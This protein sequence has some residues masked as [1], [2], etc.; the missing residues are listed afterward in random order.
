MLLEETRSIT[1]GIERTHISGNGGES[2]VVRRSRTHRQQGAL[3]AKSK[4]LVDFTNKTIAPEHSDYLLQALERNPDPQFQQTY[5]NGRPL[6]EVIDSAPIL[7]VGLKF[8]PGADKPQVNR[9]EEMDMVGKEPD[10]K[11]AAW[12]VATAGSLLSQLTVYPDLQIVHTDQT[13]RIV[14]RAKFLA[15]Q[16]D[17]RFSDQRKAL[18]LRKRQPDTVTI[19]S[20]HVTIVKDL[21]NGDWD[22]RGLLVEVDWSSL[23]DLMTNYRNL[24]AGGGPAMPP[25]ET[26]TLLET[27]IEDARRLCIRSPI[28]FRMSTRVSIINSENTRYGINLGSN[29]RTLITSQGIREIIS[30]SASYYNSLDPTGTDDSVQ[31]FVRPRFLQ[32][33]VLLLSLLN[34]EDLAQIKDFLEATYKIK[35]NRR[36]VE[37]LIL[38]VVPLQSINSRVFLDA[39]VPAI[40]NFPLDRGST[41]NDQAHSEI[42]DIF[43]KRILADEY[44]LPGTVDDHGRKQLSWIVKW[45]DQGFKSTAVFDTLQYA[46]RFRTINEIP[47]VDTN[48]VGADSSELTIEMSDDSKY[49][50]DPKD[51]E[52]IIYMTPGVYVM[53]CTTGR[54]TLQDLVIEEKLLNGELYT[55]IDMTNAIVGDVNSW[56]S[57]SKRDKKLLKWP[58][59]AGEHFSL[60]DVQGTGRLVE[61]YAFLD[62]KTL[63]VTYKVDGRRISRVDAA[64]NLARDIR[65]LRASLNLIEQRADIGDRNFLSA[66]KRALKQRLDRVRE[67][68]NFAE[69]KRMS[70]GI[71]EEISNEPVARCLYPEG[72]KYNEAKIWYGYK[73][74]CHDHNGFL[75]VEAKS[76][77]IS[78]VTWLT[79]ELVELTFT[80]LSSKMVVT[81]LRPIQ[82]G[83]WAD[84]V[85]VGDTA[86]L[87]GQY[88][89]IAAF[90]NGR[91]VPDA[92]PTMVNYLRIVSTEEPGQSRRWRNQSQESHDYIVQ[93][94][95]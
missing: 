94:F 67:H 61:V 40:E 15:N 12:R 8:L 77:N 66:E 79:G 78:N 93:R 1:D 16:N 51:L 47:P 48:P 83:Q 29:F 88:V 36:D 84:E 9:T 76:D 4:A 81:P 42:W 82:E 5:Q 13:P 11:D 54:K 50:I 34:N 59:K 85:Q 18:V 57:N 72:A 27:M 22:L 19:D 70:I 71:D 39:L 64:Q 6:E 10:Q 89:A 7:T 30:L 43:V 31:K 68:I 20:E 41:D 73:T 44:L 74:W 37:L 80:K 21:R 60:R 62:Q 46:G 33:I 2:T 17:R 75:N 14:E 56:L 53:K 69:N 45:P 65:Q 58:R 26:R 24:I 35:A 38:K 28:L 91:A 63:A 87:M 32:M 86:T 95:R 55:A 49:V 92:V 25:E 23:W 90:S 52:S 3:K